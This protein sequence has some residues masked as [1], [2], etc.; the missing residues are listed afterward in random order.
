M[1][2]WD[3]VKE[4]INAIPLI[5]HVDAKNKEIIRGVN[6]QVIQNLQIQKD[7]IKNMP[8]DKISASENAMLK[9]V[10]ILFMTEG[11]LSFFMNIIIYT[12][13]VKEH[14]DVWFEWKQKFV[15]SFDE[16][17]EV[18]LSVRLTFLEK[19]GFKFFSE[20]CPKDIRNAVA[21]QDFNIESDGTIY[22]KERKKKLAKEDSEKILMDIAKLLNL[23]DNKF[24]Y[25]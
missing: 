25:P 10:Y 15:S 20:I 21:H 16:L 24:R 1:I 7:F 8:W 6:L 18:P 9:L 5:T 12:L 23:L 14:H 22:Y 13:M 17:F 11:V 2:N 19:H 4:K 3:K